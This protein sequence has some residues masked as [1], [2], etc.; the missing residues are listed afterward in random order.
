MHILA[1]AHITRDKNRIKPKNP[2]GTIKYPYWYEV[3]EQDGRGS[4][5]FEQVCS[6]LWAIDKEVK[7]DGSRGLSRVKVIHNR[8]WDLSGFGDELTIHP[9]TGRMVA[10]E[11]EY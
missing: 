2:D 9:H 8:E 5:A 4:G 6:N 1:V 7:E 10:H 3:D 11:Q